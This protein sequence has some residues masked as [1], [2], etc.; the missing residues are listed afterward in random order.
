[1]EDLKAVAA[2]AGQSEVA[3]D[4]CETLQAVPRTTLLA[5]GDTSH[6]CKSEAQEEK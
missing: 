4:L 6:N 5:F 1:M 2:D 3:V